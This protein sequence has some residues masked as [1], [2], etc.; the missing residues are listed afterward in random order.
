MAQEIAAEAATGENRP[1]ARRPRRTSAEIRARILAAARA[2]FATRGYAGATTRQIARQADVAEPLVFNNF[3]SKAALFTE[4]VIAPFNARFSAFL[5]ASDRMP[6]DRELRS[7]HFVQSLYPFLRE[8]ADML[9]ALVKSA[10]DRDEPAL[11]GLD[12]YFTRA[13]SRMRGQYEAAGLAFDV[14]PELLVRYAFGMLAGAVLFGDWFFP[15]AAPDEAAAEAAL[16]RMLF[17]A[18]EPKPG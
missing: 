12:D 6:P 9:H 17:K 16:A 4:A 3:G 2:E 14:P 8:N 15:D 5:D 13:V 10:G 1:P 7:A 18:S 11:H